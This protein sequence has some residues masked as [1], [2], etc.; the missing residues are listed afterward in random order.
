MTTAIMCPAGQ[1][2]ASYSPRCVVPRVATQH[3]TLGVPLPGERRACFMIEQEAQ[4]THEIIRIEE[5]PSHFTM[6]PDVVGDMPLSHAEFRL[7]Y[8]YRRICRLKKKQCFQSLSVI[9]TAVKMDRQTIISAR[10][11]LEEYGLIDVQK[12]TDPSNNQ[13]MVTVT[14]LPIWEKNRLNSTGEK[15]PEPSDLGVVEKSRGVVEKTYWGSGKDVLG[16]SGISV[17]DRYL[18]SIESNDRDVTV[19]VTGFSLGETNQVDPDTAVADHYA[20]RLYDALAQK[21]KILRPPNL[22][23]WMS[24]FKKFFATNPPDDFN[25]VF[26]W[27]LENIAGEYVPRAYSATAFCRE[28]VRI[29][30]AK[31]RSESSNSFDRVEQKLIKDGK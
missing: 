24:E 6:M 9:S 4:M 7:Y 23:S 30:D 15:H 26:S 3:S 12:T 10:K 18:N 8:W 21:R 16:G 28:Y 11:K 27:Y 19:P 31:E 29:A 25:E 20:R 5:E 2:T 13:Q 17:L 22:N 1:A 14:M